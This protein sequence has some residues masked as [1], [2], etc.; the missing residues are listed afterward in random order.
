MGDNS[1]AGGTSDTKFSG[2]TTGNVKTPISAIY[3][4]VS[5]IWKSQMASHALKTTAILT[6]SA[7]MPMR[8][9]EGAGDKSLGKMRNQGNIQWAMMEQ[10]SLCACACIPEILYKE[11]TAENKIITCCCANGTG[12][13][14]KGDTKAY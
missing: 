7:Y 12:R 1:C 3:N 10:W 6:A 14:V 11:Y 13:L 2:E 9:K 5:C 4:N 8:S